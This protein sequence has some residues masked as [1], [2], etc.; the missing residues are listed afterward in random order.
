M[1]IIVTIKIIN[2]NLKDIMKIMQSW[3][4]RNTI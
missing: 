3:K 2:S 4:Q 1:V